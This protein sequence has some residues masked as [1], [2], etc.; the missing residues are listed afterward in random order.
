M[1]SKM[2]TQDMV[3]QAAA[4]LLSEGQEPSTRLIRARIGGGSFTTIGEKLDDWKGRQK[5]QTQVAIELPPPLVALATSAV[6]KV[7]SEAVEL[8]ER[9]SEEVRTD[10]QQQVSQARAELREADTIISQQD[11]T[12]EDQALR[13]SQAQQQTQELQM[14]VD[15][16]RADQR[17]AEV[18][19]EEQGRQLGDVQQK[20]ESLQRDLE[21]ARTQAQVAEMR[22]ADMTQ[23]VTENEQ[24]LEILRIK[25]EQAQTAAQLAEARATTSEQQ[26]VELR[27]DL[28]TRTQ[29]YEAALGEQA[30]LSGLVEGLNQ[31]L[32]EQSAMIQRLIPPISDQEPSQS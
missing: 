19:L 11:T 3:D 26:V 15:R 8:A 5:L 30:R 25:F 6:H 1:P 9:R 17:A 28:A 4:E 10:A 20:N 23:R 24:R 21:H 12:I 16:A 31:Q 14:E 27:A 29:Q 32:Q 22:L 18:R 7:W 13:L 2:V